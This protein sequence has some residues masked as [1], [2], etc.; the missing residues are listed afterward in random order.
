MFGNMLFL[1][2]IYWQ[3]N[4]WRPYIRTNSTAMI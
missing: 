3:I 4:G 2:G 1:L